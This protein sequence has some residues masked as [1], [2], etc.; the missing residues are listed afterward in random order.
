V[1]R[2]LRNVA[3][4]SVL[5]VAWEGAVRAGLIDGRFVPPPSVVFARMAHLLTQESFLR[6]VIATV[7]AWAIAL[8]VATAVAVPTGLLLGSVAPLRVATRATVEFLRPIPSVALIPL[9]ILVVG[10]GPAA[11][12]TLA[13]YAAVWPILYNTSYAVGEIDPLMLDSARSCGAGKVGRLVRVA[14]PHTA[15]FMFT[16]IRLA[17]AIAL[18]VV[19]SVEFLAGATRGIGNFILDASSGGGRMDLVLAGAVVAGCVGSAINQGL[20]ALGRRWFRW[21]PAVQG[22]V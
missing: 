5:L 2:P 4:P 19:V 20:A 1:D 10:G 18:I 3:G 6:D 9:V 8:G 12:I 17:G 15:P 11:K 14:L 13:A 16:G 7:L 22:S 21:D